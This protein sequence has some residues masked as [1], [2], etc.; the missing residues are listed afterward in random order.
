MIKTTLNSTARISRMLL[1]GLALILVSALE[2][3][4]II[5]LWGH[6]SSNHA[7][8]MQL[9]QRAATSLLLA[10]IGHYFICNGQDRHKRWLITLLLFNF[11]F[12]IPLL[13]AFSVLLVALTAAYPRAPQIIHSP[14]A[15]LVM[16]EF[17]LSMREAVIRFSQ[18]GIR[19]TLTQ[20]SIGAP[21]R[22][23]SLLALQGMPSRISSPL[24][25]ER[26]EDES[27]DIR[28][29]AYG[30]LDSREKA[31]NAEIHREM[32]SLRQT[33]S[34]EIR[35]ITL[36]HLA[37]LYWEMIHA[38]LAQGDLRIHALNQALFYAEEAL[39][40]SGKNA[41]L[42]FLKARILFEL[43]DFKEATLAF[44]SSANLGLHESRILPYLAEIAF[45][46]KQ[47]G[48]ARN[49]LERLSAYQPSP[50]MQDII[51]LW[52]VRARV[53][54]GRLAA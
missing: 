3:F 23:Q 45:Y 41:G 43:K 42:Q 19:S 8:L 54:S 48:T 38:R 36:R 30:L 37:E 46:R 33:E 20:P 7:L 49:L 44:E 4:D 27:D 53:L 1:A 32:L 21:K 15:G 34:G 31:I 35:L 50:I 12:F 10:M 14:F 40:L 13:G 16:P 22:L 29:I 6:A 39:K 47:Y 18:G 9:L 11:I 2:I 5:M 51:K 17:A 24:L 25:H 26:L 28:L 52:T